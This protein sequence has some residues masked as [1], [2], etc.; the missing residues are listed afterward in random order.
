MCQELSK[1]YLKKVTKNVD[2]RF[3][4]TLEAQLE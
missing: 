1:G 3:T 4:V 2:N